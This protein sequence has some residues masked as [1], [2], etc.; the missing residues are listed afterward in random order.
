VNTL[1]QVFPSIYTF[2]VPGRLTTEIMAT[3]QPTSLETFRANMAQF[4][5]HEIMGQLANEVVP[6]AQRG[7]PN[8]GLVF[9]DDRA[10]VELLSDL[11]FLS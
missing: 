7:Y 8:G 10:P 1:S 5:P 4:S 9:T 11:V 2:D 6:Q 3:M